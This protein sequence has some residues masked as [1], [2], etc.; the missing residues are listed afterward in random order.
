M[1]LLPV[2]V[3]AGVPAE[4]YVFFLVLDDIPD[5]FKTVANVTEDMTVAVLVS[6]FLSPNTEP[7][8]APVSG[9]CFFSMPVPLSALRFPPY[10]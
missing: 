10:G 1:P 4:L 2:Y 6:R 8:P 7:V 3:A 9:S 5:I